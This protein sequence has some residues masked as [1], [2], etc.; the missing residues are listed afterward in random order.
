MFNPIFVQ[1][2]FVFFINFVHPIY[3][4]EIIPTIEITPDISSI[5][6]VVQSPSPTITET[7]TISPFLETD[8]SDYSPTETVIISGHNF[9]LNTQYFLNIISDNLNITQPITTNESGSFIYNYELDGIYRPDYKVEIKDLDNKIISTITFTDRRDV[10]SALVNGVNSVNFFPKESITVTVGVNT[11]W[12]WFWNNDWRSTSWRFGNSGDWNCVDTPDHLKSGDYF[13]SFKINSPSVIGKYQLQI[14]IYALKD[15]IPLLKSDIFTLKNAITVLTPDT[16]P[17]IVTINPYNTNP[18]NQDIIV[19]ASTNEGILNTTSHT[20][21]ENGSFTF[22]ATDDA[23][24]ITN[25]TVNINNIDKNPPSTP[26]LVSPLN[27]VS[28]KGD[29]VTSDW[30]EISDAEKYFY[31]SYSDQETSQLKCNQTIFNPDHSLIINNP[32]DDTFWWRVKAIDNVENQSLWSEL[33]KLIIDNTNPIVSFLI[34]PSYPDGQNNWYWTQPEITATVFDI[35]L[36]SVKYQWDSQSGEW[37]DYISSLKL[38]SE[39]SHILYIK[40]QDSAGNIT[41]LSKEIKWDKTDPYLTPQNVFADPNPTSGNHSKIKWE[42]AKDN[43]GIDKYEIQWILNDKNNPLFNSKTVGA[44]T[45]EVD[46]NNLIKGRWTIKVVAFDQSGRAKDS[47]IDLYVTDFMSPTPTPTF[48]FNKII[49][50]VTPKIT[51]NQSTP[52]SSP[53]IKGVSNTNTNNSKPWKLFLSLGL[54][55]LYFGGRKFFSKK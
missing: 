39:G 28:L 24:N 53:E 3:A 22:I 10:V 34:N 1:F 7:P 35:N 38:N 6:T 45:T 43:I 33:R 20:F 50:V 14:R 41:N 8:K 47:A 15:C 30:S 29:Q 44:N 32:I 23:G 52:D 36:T 51:S 42:V 11:D 17:P 46:I 2:L 55:T 18:T 4:E 25:Q 9:L 40:A 27:G 26:L 5:P 31:E 21:T 16:T 13:E 12:W 49:S 19:T 48:K 37:L 54:L